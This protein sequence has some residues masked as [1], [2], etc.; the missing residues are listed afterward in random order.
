MIFISYIYIYI[1]L[2]S[3]FINNRHVIEDNR[4]E[5]IDNQTMQMLKE[6]KDVLDTSSVCEKYI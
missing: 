2:Q 3:N 1:F 4:Y 6:L 5:A